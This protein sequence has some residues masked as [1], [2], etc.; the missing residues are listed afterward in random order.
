MSVNPYREVRPNPFSLYLLLAAN[1]SA[2]HL[3]AGFPQ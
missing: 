2:V 3:L 1:Y